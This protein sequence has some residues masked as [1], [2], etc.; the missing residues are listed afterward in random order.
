MA[1]KIF[2]EQTNYGWGLTFNLTGKAPAINKRIFNKLTD[3]QSYADDFNDSAVEGL[4]LS[5]VEDTEKNN[6]VYFVQSIKKNED[7]ESASL[8]KLSFGDLEEAQNYINNELKKIQ[9]Q[10][11]T[12]KTEILSIIGEIAE[13]DSIANLINGI[14][15]ESANNK[16]EIDSYTINGK[17]VSENPTLSSDDL[18]VSENYSVLTQPSDN[19]TPGDL[20]TIAISK[21]EVMLANTTLAL[22]A[23]INDIESRLGKPAV[24]DEDNNIVSES[25]GLYKKYEELEN[26]IKNIQ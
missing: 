19:I 20:I 11:Q 2:N 1:E 5:V 3:A 9:E 21:I 7:G 16:A 15:E 8:V 26:L 23:A 12:D 13:G 6:G 14:A 4:L 24:Y 25:F 10:Y 17:L 18:Q 22:T